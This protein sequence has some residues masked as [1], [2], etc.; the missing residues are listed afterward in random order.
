M[1]KANLSVSYSA[2]YFFRQE[3]HKQEVMMFE[4]L[5]FESFSFRRYHPRRKALIK[6]LGF[7]LWKFLA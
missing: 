1:V 7:A 5:D 4:K 2:V 6:V 3:M